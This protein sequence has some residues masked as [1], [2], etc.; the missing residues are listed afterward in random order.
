MSNMVRKMIFG[1][2]KLLELV[3]WC[4]V[5]LEECILL[6]LREVSVVGGISGEERR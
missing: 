2:L 5:L 3:C 1:G 4:K 6:L